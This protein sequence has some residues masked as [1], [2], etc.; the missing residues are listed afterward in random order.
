[1]FVTFVSNWYLPLTY[2]GDAPFVSVIM[3]CF[4]CATYLRESL[5]SVLAQTFSDWELVFWDNQSSD[6]SASIFNSYSDDRFHYYLASENTTLGHARNLAVKQARGEW[7][8]FLD[9]DDLWAAEKLE[10]QINVIKEEESDLGLVYGH[11]RILLDQ[12][13]ADTN[14]GRGISTHARYRNLQQLPEGNVFSELLKENFIPLLS[15]V[16]RRLAYWQV[17]GIDPTLKQAEDYDLFLKISKEFKV[18]AVHEIVCDYRVHDSNLSHIQMEENYTESIAIVN[19]YIPS[20]NAID[21]IRSHQTAYAV[22]KIKNG[23]IVSG[24]RDLIL[25]GS[26]NFLIR[27]T[28]L[29]ILSYK[30]FLPHFL[31]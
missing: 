19:Q 16:V 2:T 25:R 8:A 28:V 24:I 11:M 21:G 10:K 29:K 23:F 22:Y 6:D 12:A 5:D 18:R 30:L 9:C 14:W 4:N 27:K 20:I 26:L 13:N 3:N 7:I 17:G 31:R 1:M 15:A